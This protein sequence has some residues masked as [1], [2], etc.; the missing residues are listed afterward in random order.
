MGR[1]VS[2]FSRSN[3]RYQPQKRTLILCEDSKS[4][5][6]YLKD[7]AHFY[8]SY[9]QVEI[10]HPEDTNPKAIVVRGIH[11]LETKQFDRVFCVIDRDKHEHFKE[12]LD[13][14]RTRPNDLTVIASYPCMELWYLLHFS[15]SR[16]PFAPAGKKSACD[17]LIVQLKNT[18]PLFSDYAKSDTEGLFDRLKWRIDDAKRN[19]ASVL[20]QAVTE[21]EM[22]PSTELH[23]LIEELDSLGNLSPISNGI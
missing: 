3:P 8:R 12:A 19:A 9:A 6:T 17:A 7:A 16:R 11:D 23:K 22:N 10:L 20:A 21:G 5:V 18:N 1:A 15:R 2:R 13:L 4:T 14:A